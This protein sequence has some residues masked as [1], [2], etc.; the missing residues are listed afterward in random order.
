AAV[1]ARARAVRDRPDRF[2]D[3]GDRQVRGADAAGARA[4]RHRLRPGDA[5]RPEA[6]ALGARAA[7]QGRG[8]GAHARDPC[9]HDRVADPLPA[10]AD[11]AARATAGRARSFPL[12]ALAAPFTH[13]AAPAAPFNR[14]KEDLLMTT[15]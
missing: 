4:G 2:A 6:R 13:R 11:L 5:R 15:I 8:D 14:T 10:P 3:V 7:G 12:G 9:R 1:V